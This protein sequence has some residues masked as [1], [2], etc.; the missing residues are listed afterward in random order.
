MIPAALLVILASVLLPEPLVLI[1]GYLSVRTAESVLDVPPLVSAG[2][3]DLWLSDLTILTISG[4]MLLRLARKPS[5][6]RCLRGGVPPGLIAF[7]AVMGVSTIIMGVQYGERVWAEEGIPLL[8]FIGLQ[9]GG[10]FLLLLS[11]RTA[12]DVERAR[13]TIGWLGMLAAATIYL[14][15]ILE[16][17]GVQLGEVNVS[18]GY[19]RYQGILGDSVKMFLIPFVFMNLL[20]NRTIG[21]ALFAIALVG[22]GGRVGLVGLIAGLVALTTAEGLKVWRQTRFLGFGMVVLVLT[23]GVG[24]DIGGMATRWVAPEELWSGLGSRASSWSLA[25]QITMDHPVLGVGFGGYPVFISRYA[26]PIQLIHPPFQTDPFSQILRVLVDGGVL[27]LSSF[28]WMMVGWISFFRARPKAGEKDLQIWV[29]S[30]FLYTI[31]LLVASSVESW[32][33]PASRVSY[34]LFLMA[35]VAARGRA[36]AP[37]HAAARGR[38]TYLTSPMLRPQRLLPRSEG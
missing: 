36:L 20:S 25:L 18:A 5:F 21:A 8:R 30:G 2:T 28:V 29:Y 33:L 24:L 32:L 6:L 19:T 12:R 4:R 38:A 23:I 10:Y 15:W 13:K 35:A 11:L 22:T 9:V 16:P 17:F 34:L 3:A 1:L 31:A 26:T 37:A 7:L 14:G 27:G